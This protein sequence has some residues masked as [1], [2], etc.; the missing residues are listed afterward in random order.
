MVI[1][2]ESNNFSK[3]AT[4]PKIESLLFYKHQKGFSVRNLEV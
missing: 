3:T 1:I 4:S 2:Y